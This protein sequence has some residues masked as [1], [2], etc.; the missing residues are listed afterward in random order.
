V[1]HRPHGGPTS[2]H[3]NLTFRV[4][5]PTLHPAFIT[6]FEPENRRGRGILMPK[7]NTTPSVERV[8]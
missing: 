2:P 6:G 4:L 5:L 7:I 3:A 1:D 8:H